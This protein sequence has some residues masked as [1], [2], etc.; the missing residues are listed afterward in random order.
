[1]KIDIVKS[2]TNHI[3][4]K[5]TIDIRFSDFT[6]AHSWDAVQQAK[7]AE[8]VRRSIELC[9]EEYDSTREY[10][11][12]DRLELDLGVF[13]TD[14][15]LNKMPEKFYQELQKILSSYHVSLNDFE[16][17]KIAEDGSFINIW[18]APAAD[19][20][21]ANPIVKN[22]EVTAFLFFLQRGYLP[23]WYSNE[24]AW[25]QEWLQKLTEENWQELRNFLKSYQENEVY[26]EP[27]LVRLISQFSD[28][29]L[30]S[31]L[32]GL[33]RKEPVEKAW[34]WLRR[35]YETLQK[36]ETNSLHNES[37][38]PSLALLR[39]HFWKNWISY[40]AGRLG[41]P[42]LTTLFA[43]IKQ[44]SLITYFLQETAENNEWM[45]NVPE[46]WYDELISLKQEEDKDKPAVSVSS[47]LINYTESE[48]FKE[49]GKTIHTDKE[50]FILVPDS[51]LVLLHPFL[52]RLF[53][54]CNWLNEKQFLNDEARNRAVNALHYLAAGDEEVPEYVLMLP[55]LLC[56]IP[57]EW[58]LEPG[59]PLTEAERA[60]CD[61][62]L[63]QVIGHW[64]A[65]RNASPAALRETFLCRPGKLFLTD[66]GWRLEVQRR[67]EDI[68]I[69]RLPWG[70]SMI[71]YS[72][73]PRRLSVAWE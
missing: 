17:G 43:L 71:K 28:R 38:F 18:S 15:L 27:A 16:E 57:L 35:F 47:E 26:Y 56:G 48:K 49:Q 44:P 24:P 30:A 25:N 42:E 61:E 45:D 32:K 13:S 19:R 46:F 59:L 34:D 53:E 68:L 51:G 58:P 52:P 40:T 4:H 65:L 8:A 1:M 73:M 21:N 50:D 2:I 3:I 20:K 64:S 9:L 11:T 33:Q 31:M 7:I 60:A 10:L 23:W 66:E 67:T 12:I 62:L 63:V 41:I 55:K 70:F 54:Y 14:E 37:S 22:S 36:A 72:W 29:F 39:R 6:T 5:Q 69:D